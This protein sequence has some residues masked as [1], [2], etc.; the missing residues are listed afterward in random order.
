MLALLVAMGW[1]LLWIHSPHRFTDIHDDLRVIVSEWAVSLLIGLYVFRLRRLSPAYF[2]LRSAGWRDIL[3]M[4]A[5][6]MAAVVLSAVAAWLGGTPRMST[7]D[8][9]QIAAMPIVLRLLLVCTAGICEEFLYRGFALEQIGELA[10]NRWIGAGASLALFTIGHA[11]RY[12]WSVTLL[13][14]LFIGGVLTAL[15]MWRRNLPVCMFMHAVTDGLALI[16]V[17]AILVHH[18][19]YAPTKLLLL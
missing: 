5:A 18:A 11:G 4:V 8:L 16:V 9:H 14:P 19:V 13:T 7:Q 2:G 12:G 10:G 6:F 15:Y 1:P 3:A 17:P